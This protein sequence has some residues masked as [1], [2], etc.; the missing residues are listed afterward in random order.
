MKSFVLTTSALAGLTLAQNGDHL[1]GGEAH[2][3]GLTCSGSSTW[4]NCEPCIPAPY[5]TSINNF[6][7]EK[8]G[9]VSLAYRVGEIKSG[10]SLRGYWWPID[11]NATVHTTFTAT[12][13]P[14]L[15]DDDMVD[16]GWTDNDTHFRCAT[17]RAPAPV[18]L[19]PSY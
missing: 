15:S 5:S 7:I 17:R 11:P 10:G 13:V 8:G 9:G 4:S 18:C 6:H 2:N 14:G 19:P 3:V 16:P 12:G 1:S